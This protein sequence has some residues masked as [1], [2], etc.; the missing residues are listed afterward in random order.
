MTNCT[1]RWHILGLFSVANEKARYEAKTNKKGRYFVDGLVW[2][3]TGK[4]LV[5]VELDGYVPGVKRLQ[6]HFVTDL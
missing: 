4:W 3:A 6:R 1:V 5:T 2:Y